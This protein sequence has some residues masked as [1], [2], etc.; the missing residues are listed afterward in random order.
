MNL[1]FDAK[2]PIFIRKSKSIAKEKFKKLE[3]IVVKVRGA[4]ASPFNAELK[5]LPAAAATVL[6]WADS[7]NWQNFNRLLK[8][9][10]V[11]DGDA[12]RLIM[13]TAE[14]LSQICRLY[15]T[16]PDLARLAG[17]AKRRLLRPPLSEELID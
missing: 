2:E 11:A 12:A 3:E 13:Q 7:D 6:T 14:H 1:Y 16:H 5:T 8:L 10:G 4:F 15:E 17:E 9:G